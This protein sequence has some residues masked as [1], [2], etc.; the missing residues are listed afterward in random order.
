MVW[1]KDVTRVVNSD[2]TV[3]FMVNVVVKILSWL[4]IEI[5][6]LCLQVAS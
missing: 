6:V 3:I 2:L 5:G 1:F 4:P